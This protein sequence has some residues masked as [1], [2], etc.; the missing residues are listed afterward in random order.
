VAWLSRLDR[1][2]F[3]NIYS[4]S[5][6]PRYGGSISGN[7]QEL[8][9]VEGYDIHIY[10]RTSLDILRERVLPFPAYVKVVP[11]DG[12]NIVVARSDI[13]GQE[14]SQWFDIYDTR[15]LNAVY[16]DSVRG[17]N[18]GSNLIVSCS[19]NFFLIRTERRAKLYALDTHQLIWAHS[20]SYEPWQI[21]MNDQYLLL[22]SFTR[23]G[24]EIRDLF[25]LSELAFL[26]IQLS[27]D[28]PK[29]FQ[30]RILIPT[31]VGFK[32]YQINDTK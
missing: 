9:E 29:F 5:Y 13:P 25:S 28:S 2:S 23:D 1:T 32:L 27:N 22:Y 17:I 6:Q 30:D 19:E 8:F 31:N 26:P 11:T 16:S 15:S 24:Y 4:R 12:T 7:A 10:D 3:S 20:F 18:T 21:G 14:T